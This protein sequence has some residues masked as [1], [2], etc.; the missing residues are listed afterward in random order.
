MSPAGFDGAAPR[1]IPAWL[2][3]VLVAIPIGQGVV[4]GAIPYQG[5]SAPVS[6]LLGFGLG[7][8][9]STAIF[10]RLRARRP[11]PPGHNTLANAAEPNRLRGSHDGGHT[12][13]LETSFPPSPIF[14][15]GAS[16]RRDDPVL[17][18]ATLAPESAR[19]FEGR[20]DATGDPSS[21]AP[22]WADWVPT[23]RPAVRGPLRWWAGRTLG[24]A[25][26]V[27][28]VIFGRPDSGPAAGN[29]AWAALRVGDCFNA[30]DVAGSTVAPLPSGVV[31]AP[32][33]DPVSC[34]GTHTFEVYGLSSNPEAPGVAFPG[35][36]VMRARTREVCT[37]QF[38]GYVGITLDA[39]HLGARFVSPSESSWTVGDRLVVCYL[40]DP[41]QARTTRSQK[42]AFTP[43]TSLAF[44]FSV[45]MPWG[46]TAG[47][48]SGDATGTLLSGPDATIV[49]GVDSAG[50]ASADQLA[51]DDATYLE[52]QGAS[53]LVSSSATVDG[54]EWSILEYT[55]SA[56]DGS[57]LG[58]DALSVSGET[59]YVVIWSSAA[60]SRDTDH[61]RFMEVLASFKPAS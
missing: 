46:W 28:V 32:V 43:Y 30:G 5:L 33:I 11:L 59:A 44:G 38:Q 7:L 15:P 52:G 4:F 8:A 47:A 57:K 35:E 50:S 42:Q 1:R 34:L 22:P 14:G 10:T 60:G 21:T 54:I 19:V 45:S 12:E 18:E 20:A 37:L 56:G 2:R 55:N 16:P 31:P 41:N 23:Q 25:I 29:D 40:Y 53:G 58:I 9:L 17:D 6:A 24:L 26:V 36:Q 39:S 51:T 3:V 61:A 48:R 27:V 49:I 13:A